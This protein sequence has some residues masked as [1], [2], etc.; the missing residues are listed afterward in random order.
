M[1]DWDWDLDQTQTVKITTSR[2]KGKMAS[3]GGQQVSHKHSQGGQQV[4]N[5]HN[6]GGQ[7]LTNILRPSAAIAG[8]F[9]RR[10]QQYEQ[11]PS[12]ILD[13]LV[14]VPSTVVSRYPLRIYYEQNK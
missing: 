8:S 11:N 13:F 6:E 12:D 10:L 5:T 3:G 1:A 14:F 4:S 7:K 2:R 9:C